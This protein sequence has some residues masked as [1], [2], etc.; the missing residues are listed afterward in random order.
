MTG[1]KRGKSSSTPDPLADAEL[2]EQF[3]AAIAAHRDGRL[4]DASAGYEAVLAVHAEHADA[5]H[6]LGVIASQSGRHDQ[7]VALIDRALALNADNPDFHSNRGIALQGDG[8][9]EAALASYDQALALRPDFVEAHGNRAAVLRALHRTA[10]AVASYQ[11]IIALR[12][13]QFDAH[14]HCARLL[15]ELGQRDAALVHLDNALQLAPDNAE[16]HNSRGALLQELRRFDQA[17][18]AYDAAIALL[19]TYVAAHSNRGTALIEL[20]DYER[21]L[22]NFDRA[23]ALR[24]DY[25]EAYTCRGVAL[26][27]L[28]RLPAALA[29]HDRALAI[30][31]RL[32]KAHLNRGATLHQMNRLDEAIASYDRA[33]AID[34]DSAGANNNKA[35]SLLLKGDLGQGWDLYEWRWKLGPAVLVERRLPAPRWTGSEELSGRRVLLHGEQGFGD[36]LQF[37]R[38]AQ[39]VAAR[40]AH[41]ILEVAPAMVELMRTVAGVQEVIAG[42]E[43]LPAFDLY[44]PLLSVPRL[45]GTR[46]DNIPAATPYLNADPACLAQWE[47][48]LGPRTRPRVALA[49]RGNAQHPNDHN[50]SIPLAQLLAHLPRD[51]EYLSLQKD[52]RDDDQA[53]LRAHPE[54]RH[55]GDELKDFSDSAAL[56]MLADVVISV[57]T[58]LAHLAGG[59]GRPTWLLLCFSPDWR[60]LLE[61]SDSPWYPSFRLY[62]QSSSGDW[63]TVLRRVGGDLATH[64][65]AVTT[66][67]VSAAPKR[68]ERSGLRPIA[69]VLVATNHG[70]LLVNRNDHHQVGTSGY[71]VGYQL[72]NTSAFDAPE[73]NTARTLLSLRR[74]HYGDGV[75]AVDCGANIGVHSV[76]WARHMDGWGEVIAIEAQ[77]RIF[78]ALAGNLSINNCFNAR[79]LWAAVGA[80]AGV[81]AVPQ[82]DY[83]RSGSFGSLEIRQH[84][85]NEFIGQPVSYADEDMRETRLMRIDDLALPR[86]D[87]IK[88]DIEGMELEAL[89]GAA[90]A[91]A[92]Q[93]PLLIIE[94]I[95]SDEAALHALLEAAGY[96]CLPFGINILAVHAHDPTLAAI[97]LKKS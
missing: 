91:L 54:V 31:P 22:P 85:G 20:R 16:A 26:K 78:Y 10:E 83:H 45:C 89:R 53:T 25:A 29:D 59:L 82:P 32:I 68:S 8:Q 97:N 13:A 80:E 43:A 96:R 34:P 50:R 76:E 90:M 7:A 75:V 46:L 71:G 15:R 55:L 6:L 63:P 3:S 14:L 44:S 48:R 30:E 17:I 4:H 74:R 2:A 49:W 47:T 11:Q 65:S 56:C 42:G 86:L 62:R 81:I 77:E 41:V 38:Y 28:N 70:T 19:P 40:G 87:L 94:K 58:S 18:S 5:L 23:L 9:L 66:Q 36:T 88:I 93:R 39:M 79:A 61:R 69:W 95:K 21:A 92:R 84:Q 51:C 33:L 37:C 35:V 64:F 67:E 72:L 73:V 27:E 1:G 52:L 12:P 57:D 24:A 60:W